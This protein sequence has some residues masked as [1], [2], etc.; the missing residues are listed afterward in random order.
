MTNR[1]FTISEIENLRV[2]Y[3]NFF[4]EAIELTKMFKSIQ[5]S[6]ATLQAQVP[7]HVI[8]GALSDATATPYSTSEFEQMREDM[9]KTL[10]RIKKYVPE[11]DAKMAEQLTSLGDIVSILKG[12]SSN[13][14]AVPRSDSVELDS[15]SFFN[16]IQGVRLSMQEPLDKVEEIYESMLAISKG[17]NAS[18]AAYAGDPINVCTGNF[19][20]EK[21]DL[22]VESVFPLVFKRTF[23]SFGHYHGVLGNYSDRKSVV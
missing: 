18:H 4:N 8:S 21:Q 11:V 22:V 9:N 16:I 12:I 15:A 7:G 20:I 23:N 14:L 17:L 5:S 6:A 3:E 2:A 1:V 19:T 13:Y 10:N